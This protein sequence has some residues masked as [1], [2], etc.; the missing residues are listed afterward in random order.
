MSVRLQEAHIS[1]LKE[2]LDA[3][4]DASLQNGLDLAVS[5]LKSVPPYGHREVSTT[6]KPCFCPIVNQISTKAHAA[7][8]LMLC[9]QGMSLHNTHDA[10]MCV[11]CNVLTRLLHSAQAP[12]ALSCCVHALALTSTR[13]P[14]L[15]SLSHTIDYLACRLST[16]VQ[17]HVSILSGQNCLQKWCT[18]TCWYT[19]PDALCWPVHL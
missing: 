12:H 14:K 18:G 19:G 4:G 9:A 6:D 16:S 17:Q 15:E 8:T 7:T 2:G 10:I 5:A 13:Q 3:G 11:L 1:K